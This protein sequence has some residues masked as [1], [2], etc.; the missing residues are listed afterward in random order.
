MEL[1]GKYYDTGIGDFF[2]WASR[3]IITDK[4]FPH[5]LYAIHKTE[6]C[7]QKVVIFGKVFFG[8]GFLGNIF[9]QGFLG[10]IFWATF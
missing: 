8:Q 7:A 10:N 4:Q 6:I 5:P 1:E 3:K 9:G 2:C